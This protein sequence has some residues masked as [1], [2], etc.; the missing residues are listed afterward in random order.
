M[1]KIAKI[2][3]FEATFGPLVI[4]LLE[5]VENSV[6]HRKPST[7][8]VFYETKLEIKFWHFTLRQPPS[9]SARVQ[10]PHFS[11]ANKRTLEVWRLISEIYG[12]IRA[13]QKRFAFV[14]AELREIEDYLEDY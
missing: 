2:Q 11:I 1:T 5:G 10:S 8:G 6:R 4:W 13:A 3:R 7:V 12:V 9:A 14:M